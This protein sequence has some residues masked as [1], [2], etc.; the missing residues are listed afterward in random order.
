MPG[1]PWDDWAEGGPDWDRWLD[2][3]L[4]ASDLAAEVEAGAAA[5]LALAAR[6]P[7]DAWATPGTVGTWSAHECLA[8][9]LVWCD[10]T[11]DVFVR[12]LDKTLRPEDFDYGDMD[13]F[14]ERTT[15]E[16]AAASTE[17]LLGAIG[18]AMAEVARLL[19]QLPEREWRA[20][21]R[22]R[23]VVGGA[24]TEHL[25]N[26]HGDLAQFVG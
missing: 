12:S 19:R 14:N 10:Y 21:D 17:E 8:H 6:V 23:L 2:P 26:H 20:R 3:G 16:R 4:T 1:E 24:I 5:F 13:A 9:I 22:Y 15:A 11:R 18:A 25:P 7:P